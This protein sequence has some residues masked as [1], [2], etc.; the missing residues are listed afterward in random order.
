MLQVDSI[1]SNSLWKDCLVT[2]QN[3]S[4]KVG[5]IFNFNDN[6][7][8]NKS[9]ADKND[10]R[11][12]IPENEKEWIN[13]HYKNIKPNSLKIETNTTSFVIYEE[14]EDGYEEIKITLRKTDDNRT[15]MSKDRFGKG[16][17][18]I[19][20]EIDNESGKILS[21]QTKTGN[22]MSK[23]MVFND[24]GKAT[25]DNISLENELLDNANKNS[26]TDFSKEPQNG[27]LNIVW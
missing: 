26:K 16:V 7:N 6:V 3:N 4:S 8:E 25:T 22:T 15:I 14:T 24:N 12:N 17:E 18:V 2:A 10:K 20:Y 23:R 21:K 11:P 19:Y 13:G 9:C 5:L 1:S 27:P